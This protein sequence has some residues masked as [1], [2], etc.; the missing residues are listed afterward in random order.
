MA[1]QTHS[2]ASATTNSILTLILGIVSWFGLSIL[3]AI[4]A[5]VLGNNTLREGV[6]GSDR[7]VTQIGRWLGIINTVLTIAIVVLALFGIVTIPFLAV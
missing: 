3:A 7:T 5:W 1:N 2:S 4:P 6:T